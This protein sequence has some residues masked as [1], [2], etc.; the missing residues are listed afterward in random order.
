MKVLQWISQSVGVQGQ[1]IA[2][3][4]S[5]ETL[6]LRGSSRDHRPP[7]CLKFTVRGVVPKACPGKCLWLQ[8]TASP[9]AA[10][11]CYPLDLISEEVKMQGQ[12]SWLG[13]LL[14]MLTVPKDPSSLVSVSLVTGRGQISI[15]TSE[16]TNLRS[17]ASDE[18]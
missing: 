17:W 12:L 6:L 10:N 4:W 11:R 2:P 7:P 9:K 15:V 14:I 3:H 1:V 13:S 16:R 8:K 5:S 18:G